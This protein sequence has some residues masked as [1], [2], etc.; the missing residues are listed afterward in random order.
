[1]DEVVAMPVEPVRF[2]SDASRKDLKRGILDTILGYI[3]RGEF[4]S[5]SS[6]FVLYLLLST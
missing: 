5:V 6:V 2:E 3:T 1:M 4:N